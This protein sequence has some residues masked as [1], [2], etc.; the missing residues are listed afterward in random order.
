MVELQLEVAF[1]KIGS[2]I[3]LMGVI[4]GN[5]VREYIS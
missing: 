4:Y 5:G 1:S 3:L 2:G